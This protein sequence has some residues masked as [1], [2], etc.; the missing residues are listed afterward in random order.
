MLGV[1]WEGQIKMNNLI[2]YI[3]NAFLIFISI[4]M[5]AFFFTEKLYLV[6]V[7]IILCLV[8]YLIFS[9]VYFPGIGNIKKFVFTQKD[10]KKKL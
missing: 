5:A 7:L 10:V 1:N 2:N 3:L 9:D 6:S 8:I 4:L